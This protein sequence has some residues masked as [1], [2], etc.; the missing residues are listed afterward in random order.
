MPYHNSVHWMIKNIFECTSNPSIL[1]IGV[2][3]GQTM[4]KV[5]QH[6]EKS[7]KPYT[8]IGVDVREDKKV[9]EAL[10]TI[11]RNKDQTVK[12]KIA[13]SLE[14]LPEYN[15]HNLKFD[16]ILLDGDHNYHTVSQELEYLNSLLRQGGTAI[17]DDYGGPW[18]NKD[19][20]YHNRPTHN[21]NALTTKPVSC[22]KRGVK[23][24]VDD[25]IA[26]NKGWSMSKPLSGVSVV[27]KWHST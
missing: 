6:F 9:V 2:D 17:C 26:K 27:L 13:N 11:E 22:D 20:F 15:R 18:G 5:M 10:E 24:A 16:L 4:I 12:Y 14:W 8:Y 3:A 25:F 7:G 21:G 1:E 19:M 23:P